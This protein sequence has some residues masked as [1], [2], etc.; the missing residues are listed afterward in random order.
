MWIIFDWD[1]SNRKLIDLF[2]VLVRIFSL[3]GTSKRFSWI[4][5]EMELSAHMKQTRITSIQILRWFENSNSHFV[6]VKLFG[7]IS[8]D[9]MMTS[10]LNSFDGRNQEK[11]MTNETVPWQLFQYQNIVIFKL[12]NK[13][14]YIFY[15]DTTNTWLDLVMSWNRLYEKSIQPS[16]SSL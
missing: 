6:V 13:T 14:T 3:C 12:W 15:E 8:I 4:W 7:W 10:W 9:K 1:N 2:F 11:E 16:H 5:T